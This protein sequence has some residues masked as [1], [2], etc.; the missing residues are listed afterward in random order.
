[1]VLGLRQDILESIKHLH[2]ND[3]QMLMTAMATEW[4]KRNYNVER[5]GKPSWKKLVEA[6]E[7]KSGGHNTALAQDIARRHSGIFKHRK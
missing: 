3:N 1:M 4:L 2:Q 5:F 7:A 6:V